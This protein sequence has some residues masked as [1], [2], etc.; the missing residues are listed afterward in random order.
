MEQSHFVLGVLGGLGPI[1]SASFLATIYRNF[2]KVPEQK[3][4]RILLC[5]DPTYP[6]RTENF[7][8][9]N[10][11]RILSLAI[12]DIGNLLHSG[13]D[14]VLVCCFTFHYI[15]PRLPD[16]LRKHVISLPSLALKQLKEHPQ[17]TLLLCTKGSR[18]L[19]IFEKDPHWKDV[20]KYIVF[21]SEEDQN[22][23]HEVIYNLKR[24]L[25]PH[26]GLRHLE[27]IFS[28]YN[29]LSWILGC[30]EL[31]LLSDLRPRSLEN[32]R[33]IDALAIAAAQLE[34][35]VLFLG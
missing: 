13:A 3:M 30:T 29:C 25:D 24:N 32:I 22:K 9:G 28:S 19:E 21:P 15:L 8:N 4:P 17:K 10:E 11:E 14:K 27:K 5:S 31:H 12:R 33:F 6:D 26:E 35:G 23:I 18:R 2:D 1:A 34:S 16:E 20:E 7:L